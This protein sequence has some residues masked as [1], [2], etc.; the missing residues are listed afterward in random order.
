MVTVLRAA[1]VGR[2]HRE[3][4]AVGKERGRRGAGNGDGHFDATGSE[5]TIDYTNEYFER[6]GG[7]ETHLEPAMKS[8]TAI[9]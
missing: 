5:S 1:D 4:E 6:K 3:A 8:A 7:K 2:K 9:E